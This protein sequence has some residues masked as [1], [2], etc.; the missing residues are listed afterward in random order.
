MP[1]IVEIKLL[2]DILNQYIR[3]KTI[4]WHI[5]KNNPKANKYN[6]FWEQVKDKKFK[7]KRIHQKGKLIIFDLEQNGKPVYIFNE[8]RLTGHW[9]RRPVENAKHRLFSVRTSGKLKAIWYSDQRI[10]GTF[11]YYGENSILEMGKR[12]ESRGP[13]ILSDIK[14]AKEYTEIL[15]TKPE[16]QIVKAMMDQ[17]LVSGVGNWI[18]SDAMYH[19]KIDPRQRIKNMSN[20]QIGDL[21]RSIMWIIN[22]SLELG[23]SSDYIGFNGK[24]GGYEFLIYGQK[25]VKEGLV[26]MA[27][28]TDGRTTHWVPIMFS[29]V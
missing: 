12:L 5:E 3:G 18:K 23:G 28:F 15:R 13:D 14:S 8:L 24:K 26:K 6:K 17:E 19:A 10:F 27:K 20:K 29:K 22:K 16:W 2:T 21:Y 25:N 7:V 9:T 1:E 4:R 11:D